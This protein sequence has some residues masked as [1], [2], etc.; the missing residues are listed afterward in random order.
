MELEV[1][2]LYE[3]KRTMNLKLAIGVLMGLTFL[4]RERIKKA[5]TSE[6]MGMAKKP[7]IYMYGWH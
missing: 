2:L 4:A 6:Q 1:F 5:G 3:G 7:W